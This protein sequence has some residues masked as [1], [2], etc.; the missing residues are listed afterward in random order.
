MLRIKTE[1][2][3]LNLVL[4]TVEDSGTGIDPLDRIFDAFFTTKSLGIG[5]GPSICRSIMESH[6]GR[7]SM[8]TAQPHKSIFYVSLPTGYPTLK[9]TDEAIESPSSRSFGS[10]V[11]QT[12]TSSDWRWKRSPSMEASRRS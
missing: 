9:K 10:G 11:A 5:M 6:D 3:K 2:N 4:I 1:V 12:E 8:A 7:L